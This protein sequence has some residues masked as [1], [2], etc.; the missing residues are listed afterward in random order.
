MS[1]ESA[2]HPQG[3]CRAQTLSQRPKQDFLVVFFLSIL[4]MYIKQSTRCAVR[5]F[6]RC[7][8]SAKARRAVHGRGRGRR[9]GLCPGGVTASGPTGGFLLC[10]HRTRGGEGW[11]PPTGPARGHSGLSGAHTMSAAKS[12]ARGRAGSGAAGGGSP[13]AQRGDGADLG[14]GT[15]PRGASL[16]NHLSSAPL[17]SV[18]RCLLPTCLHSIENQRALI[19]PVTFKPFCHTFHQK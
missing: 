4:E 10:L 8:V 2:P 6:P 9:R 5:G 7:S 16:P 15:S 1:D 11:S 19:S 14:R 12:G 13:R 3:S 18:A 17:A